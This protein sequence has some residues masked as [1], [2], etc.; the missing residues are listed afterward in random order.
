L[1]TL[2]ADADIELFATRERNIED[3]H[4]CA[5]AMRL[6]DWDHWRR[7]ILPDMFCDFLKYGILLFRNKASDDDDEKPRNAE[8]VS[9]MSGAVDSVAS[10]AQLDVDQHPDSA[11]EHVA[12]RS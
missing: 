8:S 3:T 5:H 12:P 4:K 6:M 10:G 9:E 2:N 1:Q 11:G 7:C